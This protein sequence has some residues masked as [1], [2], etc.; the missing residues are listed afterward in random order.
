MRT[1]PFLAALLEAEPTL[2]DEVGRTI[3]S[4]G[5]VL[6]KAGATIKFVLFPST[7][8]VVSTASLADGR[9]V[10]V[11]LLG[12][13]SVVGASAA[14]GP[15]TH[16]SNYVGQIPG[17]AWVVRADKLQAAANKD[18]SLRRLLFE[19]ERVMLFQ[20]QQRVIC[21]A[22]HSIEQRLATR[23][24]RA[25]DVAEADDLFATQESMAEWL[26]VQRASLSLAASKFKDAGL[27][28]YRRGRIT[29]RDKAGLLAE[30]CECCTS[31]QKQASGLLETEP[32]ISV[33]ADGEPAQLLSPAN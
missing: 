10:E 3:F 29:I 27:I 18:E 28:D 33:V 12:R 7:G 5:Q 17:T 20:A 32:L 23:L 26:G 24:L 9:G 13:R 22:T 19:H 31:L 8:L 25:S 14:F 30:A 15:A 11:G 16:L 2:A 4:T 6:A 21:N 1:N